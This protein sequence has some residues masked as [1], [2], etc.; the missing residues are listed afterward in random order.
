MQKPAVK[1]FYRIYRRD[2]EPEL[3]I[4]LGPRKLVIDDATPEMELFLRELDGSHSAA[5]LSQRYSEAGPWLA[6]LDEAG[7]IEDRAI[8]V[9]LDPVVA[10]RWSRQINYFRLFEREGWNGIDAMRRVRDARVVVVGTG[11]GGSTL[12]RLLNAAGVGHLEAVDFDSFALDNLP[13]HATLDEEDVGLP[14]LD[15]LSRHLR[16]QNSSVDFITHPRKLESSE[17]LQEIVAGADFFI[18]AY[19]RPRTLAAHWTNAA[20]LATGV[21]FSSIGVTDLGARVGP[22]VVPGESACWRCVGISDVDFVKVEETAALTGATVV[23]LAGILVNEILK[24]LTG[25]AP[26]PIVGRTLYINTGS[27]TFDFIPHERQA[28][29]PACG[30]PVAAAG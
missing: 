26:S 20:G 16:L 24:T 11:A 7:V 2:G 25:L 4:G 27:L 18:Q 17:E 29:C 22:T 5:E 15:V 19:D 3:Y 10:E 12:L 9:E 13:T 14:K 23:M 21:P 30:M 6:A 28:D 1:P 8:P